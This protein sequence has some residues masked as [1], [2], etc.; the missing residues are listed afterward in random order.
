MSTELGESS[1]DA[2]VGALMSTLVT[3]KN[4]VLHP[5]SFDK[6][7]G[8]GVYL[9]VLDTGGR[10][11]A[12]GVFACAKESAMVRDGGK[13]VSRK[14][15]GGAVWCGWL[16]RWLGVEKVKQNLEGV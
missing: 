13:C 12:R 4:R 11:E 15:D 9:V 10:A 2:G 16:D 8:L 1:R 7:L 6:R 3:P 14:Q 5:L